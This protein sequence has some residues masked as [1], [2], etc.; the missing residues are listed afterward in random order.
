MEYLKKKGLVN[1]ARAIAKVSKAASYFPCIA[2]ACYLLN[3]S[4]HL[5]AVRNG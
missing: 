4:Y 5:C 3:I 2:K 1:S